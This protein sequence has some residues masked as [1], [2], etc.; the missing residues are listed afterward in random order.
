MTRFLVLVLLV[1]TV[2]IGCSPLPA[3][4]R[5]ASFDLDCP[6]ADLSTQDLGGQTYGVR[7]CGKQATYVLVAGEGGRSW[8]MN[9]GGES[10]TD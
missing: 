3:L 7:G 6:E 10:T 2:L 5:R 4:L 9:S 1:A 8:V